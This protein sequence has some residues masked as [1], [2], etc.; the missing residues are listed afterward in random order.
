VAAAVSEKVC[1]PA[2][3][4]A[5]IQMLGLPAHQLF[6]TDPLA[7]RIHAML[8]HQACFMAL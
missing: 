4:F 3:R 5:A 8:R 6:T 1:V 2:A 7:T